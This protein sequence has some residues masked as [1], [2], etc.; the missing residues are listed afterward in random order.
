MV[1]A[2]K[3]AILGAGRIGESLISGLLSSEWRKPSEVAATSRLL[4]ASRAG[5]D[6][7][8][9]AM[10]L[11]LELLLMQVAR[12]VDADSME[13]EVAREGTADAAVLARLRLMIAEEAI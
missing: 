6:P 5:E 7:Q 8:V 4:T 11:D 13:R 2:R 3:I 9:R 1:D 12:A 10:L